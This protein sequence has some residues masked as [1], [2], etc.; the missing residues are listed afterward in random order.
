MIAAKFAMASATP[1]GALAGSSHGCGSSLPR[2]FVYRLPP[3]YRSKGSRTG[4]GFGAPVQGIGPLDGVT[5]YR[6]H[7]YGAGAAAFEEALAHPCRTRD[8]AAAD[9]FFLPAFATTNPG[10][11]SSWCAE[12]S[13]TRAE[14]NRLK[15]SC[16]ANATFHRLAEQAR[17]AAGVPYYAARGGADHLVLT[18]KSGL[19]SYDYPQTFEVNLRNARLAG[20]TKLAVEA[21]PDHRIWAGSLPWASLVHMPR[22]APWDTAPWRWPHE[23]RPTLVALALG[24]RGVAKKSFQ[25]LREALAKSCAAHPEACE[26]LAFQTSR[27]GR[28]VDE[29]TV[30]TAAL[31]ARSTF[32]LQPGGD[33][34]SRKGVLDAVTLGCIP[35]FFQPA[36]AALWPWHWGAWGRNA[37]VVLPWPQGAAE[38]SVALLQRIEGSAI[39]AMRRSLAEHAHCLHYAA[40]PRAAGGDVT[41]GMIGSAA[42]AFDVILAGS[43]RRSAATPSQAP[44]CRAVPVGSA[45]RPPPAA[46]RRAAPPAEPER[47]LRKRLSELDARETANRSK[48]Y[49]FENQ[50]GETC[51]KPAHAAAVARERVRGGRFQ[52]THI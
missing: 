11:T 17:T 51:A 41:A 19:G 15:R 49:L 2:L 43:W 6:T 13:S 28:P 52:T 30:V 23:P 48:A 18:P 35:V 4:R 40:P 8:P 29:P 25:R 24:N 9:L 42:D 22:D 37:S 38:D 27:S 7:N 12:Q 32:C 31:Y 33:S 1:D 39:A 21:P 36:A 10:S 50:W 20:W 3:G 46:L 45:P 16:D 47:C 34:P 44:L 5:L 14:R 26:R